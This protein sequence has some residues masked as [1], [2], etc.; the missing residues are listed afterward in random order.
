MI[1]VGQKS[2]RSK[3]KKPADVRSTI[4]QTV[5]YKVMKKLVNIGCITLS[6]SSFRSR[7]L[8]YPNYVS[9]CLF[10]RWTTVFQDEILAHALP[11]SFSLTSSWKNASFS[12]LT[13]ELSYNSSLHDVPLFDFFQTIAMWKSLQWSSFTIFL[14]YYAEPL[15]NSSVMRA[16][17]SKTA[18]NM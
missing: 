12:G 14:A 5:S 6:L 18:Y 2:L 13:L 1:Y 7:I 17:Q 9:M 10:S 15:M 4:W 8:L 16:G 3:I 11:V